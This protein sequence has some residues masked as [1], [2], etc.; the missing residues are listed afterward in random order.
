MEWLSLVVTFFAALIFGIM[1][2]RS[3]KKN[4]DYIK[5][6]PAVALFII[7]GTMARVEYAQKQYEHNF[8]R[9]EF[10][11]IDGKMECI[12]IASQSTPAEYA[13]A[14]MQDMGKSILFSMLL[15][16]PFELIGLT[17]GMRSLKRALESEA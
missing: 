6:W 17:L 3:P 5:N 15:D 9:C 16:G 1:A 12:P 4:W 8:P 13:K 7:S 14:G 11:L 2:R 10:V